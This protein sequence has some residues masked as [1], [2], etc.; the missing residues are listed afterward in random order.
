M[1]SVTISFHHLTDKTSVHFTSPYC[2]SFSQKCA[3]GQLE[4]QS[5]N[6]LQKLFKESINK[7]RS[8]EEKHQQGTPFTHTCSIIN[9]F[10][11]PELHTALVDLLL[12]DTVNHYVR[13]RTHEMNRASL[14]ATW[15]STLFGRQDC[16]NKQIFERYIYHFKIALPLPSHIVKSHPITQCYTALPRFGQKIQAFSSFCLFVTV[17]RQGAL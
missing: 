7:P 13:S 12:R 16:V 11:L 1:A 9:K 4:P 6:L 17:K 3:F 10:I 2:H 14:V 15:A 8:D 5:V